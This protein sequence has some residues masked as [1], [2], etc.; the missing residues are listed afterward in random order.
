MMASAFYNTILALVVVKDPEAVPKSMDPIVAPISD[1]DRKY[2]AAVLGS[3][4]VNAQNDWLTG[5]GQTACLSKGCQ[6][7]GGVFGNALYLDTGDDNSVL[8]Q[9]GPG[10]IAD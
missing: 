3:D 5:E 6:A 4:D 9:K 1:A 8:G 7:N 2:A 10:L